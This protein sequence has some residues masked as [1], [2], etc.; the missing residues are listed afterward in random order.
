N[1]LMLGVLTGA[2]FTGRVAP[3]E[4]LGMLLASVLGAWVVVRAWESGRGAGDVREGQADGPPD[5]KHPRH[6]L[7]LDDHQVHP[8]RTERRRVSPGRAG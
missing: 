5:Q 4:F 8:D 7:W 2:L 3:V 6:R 1:C